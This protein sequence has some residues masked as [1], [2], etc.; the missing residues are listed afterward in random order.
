MT[1]NFYSLF[2]QKN[3]N[4][5][6]SV[7]AAADNMNA[8]PSRRYSRKTEKKRF[9][10]YPPDASP[11]QEMK[12]ALRKYR[13]AIQKGKGRKDSEF[14][15]PKDNTDA[16]SVTANTE[17]VMKVVPF[18]SSPKKPWRHASVKITTKYPAMVVRPFVPIKP[19]LYRS[20]KDKW[21]MAV[22]RIT[23]K[24]KKRT[25]SNDDETDAP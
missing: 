17:K 11:P 6:S 24:N 8:S 21:R 18:S 10:A 2:T 12:D 16:E 1:R 7:V 3:N 19:V 14:T 15:K 9:R 4:K 20:A 13:A 23:A 25:P 5:K 22:R